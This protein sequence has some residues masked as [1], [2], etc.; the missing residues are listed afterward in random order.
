M[1]RTLS[2]ISFF[3]VSDC[4]ATIAAGFA[5]CVHQ[6]RTQL[7]AGGLDLFQLLNVQW[8]NSAVAAH[9]RLPFA[10]SAAALVGN[11]RALWPAFVAHLADSPSMQLPASPLNAYVVQTVRNAV[12]E[13]IPRDTVLDV[14]FDFEVSPSRVVAM[15]KLAHVSGLA[16]LVPEAHLVVHREAGP[17]LALRALIVFDVPPEELGLSQEPPKPQVTRRVRQWAYPSQ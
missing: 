5:A 6:L 17:W 10:C 15:Q 9:L 4:A 2:L 3:P 1:K 7:A 14:R 8:Y 12:A 11:T 16:H 13:T